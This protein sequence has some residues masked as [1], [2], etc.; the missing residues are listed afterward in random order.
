[1]KTQIAAVS[2]ALGAFVG[3]LY[4]ALRQTVRRGHSPAPV[5]EVH[6]FAAGEPAPAE[7]AEVLEQRNAQVSLDEA[8]SAAPPVLVLPGLGTRPVA[9]R[10]SIRME[11]RRARV[12]VEEDLAGDVHHNPTGPAVG[13]EF[14]P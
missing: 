1:M 8:P 10:L 2:S 9:P 7:V 11:G 12:A 13:E 14:E 4:A 5:P 6:G 3:L